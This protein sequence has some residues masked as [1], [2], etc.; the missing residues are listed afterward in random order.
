MTSGL[1]PLVSLVGIAALLFVLGWA[2]QYGLINRIV[3]RPVLTTLTLTFGLDMIVYNF[4]TL[5]VLG[6]ATAGGAGPGRAAR[7]RR[8]RA[9]RSR[10]SPW[11]WRWR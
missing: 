3:S 7:L 6:N 10:S 9:S 8:R 2:L 1:H 4:M 5:A 11:C